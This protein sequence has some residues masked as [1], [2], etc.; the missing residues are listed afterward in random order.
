MA[1]RDISPHEMVT[2][3]TPSIY[4]SEAEWKAYREQQQ[5]AKNQEAELSAALLALTDINQ[6]FN[7][8]LPETGA[9]GGRGQQGGASFTQAGS[10]DQ[11]TVKS[12][13]PTMVDQLL[14]SMSNPLVADANGHNL[15]RTGKANTT[16]AMER[17]NAAAPKWYPGVTATKQ[18]NG[19][20]SLSNSVVPAPGGSMPNISNDMASTLASLKTAT[21]PDIARGLLANVRESAALKATEITAE[22]MKFAGT[23][24]GVPVLEQQ[25]REAEAA[26]R[27]TPGWYPGIGDS[28]G[29]ARIRSTLLTTRSSVDNEAKNYLA[30][31]TQYAATQVALKTAEAEA[32]R[33]SALGDRKARIT[34]EMLLRSQIKE[35]AKIEEANALNASLSPEELK[36]LLVINPTAALIQD[37]GEKSLAI[38]ATIKGLSNKP[39][40]RE[41]LAANEL[42]L[43]ILAVENNPDALLLT[44]K[45]EQEMN[46]SAS[47]QEINS[48][49]NEIRNLATSNKNFVTQAVRQKFGTRIDSTEAKAYAAELGT[50]EVGLDAKGKADMRQRKYAMALDLYR[51]DAT[52]RFASDTISWKVADP[53]FLAAQEK[54]FK[55]TGKRDLESVLTAYLDG[56]DSATKLQKLNMFQSFARKA[57]STQSQSLFGVPDTLAMDAMIA[58]HAKTSGIW[59]AMWEVMNISNKTAA[60]TRGALGVIGTAGFATDLLLNK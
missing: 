41:A 7:S 29:T 47:E 50:S 31:N 4:A 28:P 5:A 1:T 39:S 58:Q 54:A 9:Q 22:A 53:E 8:T 11:S 59:A 37:P 21:D 2:S 57:A 44:I 13:E 51:K 25:L 19:T 26:D 17:I 35:D 12:L 14:A 43:P 32:T 40:R 6:Q 15:T 33:I 24:L 16:G 49:I 46:P 48:R 3:G 52:A 56:A 18:P 60:G 36:R 27:A 45:K 55:V 23:K 42:D 38:A 30:T 34:D 10:P 20:I